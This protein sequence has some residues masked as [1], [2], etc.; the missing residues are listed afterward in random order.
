[1]SNPLPHAEELYSQDGSAREEASR[2]RKTALVRQFNDNFG[3]DENDLE[4]WHKLCR[5]IGIRP[6]PSDIYS[7]RQAVQATHVNMVD[8]VQASETGGTVPVFDSEQE[9]SEYTIATGKFFPR[10][11]VESSDLLRH[12]L[13][14]INDPNSPSSLGPRGSKRKRNEYED[15]G[16]DGSEGESGSGEGS[17]GD[18]YSDAEEDNAEDE[19]SSDDDE[20]ED[21][22]RDARQGGG[23]GVGYGDDDEE[24]DE[25]DED[26]DDGGGGVGAYGDNYTN[27]EYHYDGGYDEDEGDNGYDDYY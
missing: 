23:S 17:E 20:D 19:G 14:H 16:E 22:D 3:N 24:E 26:D 5:V 27:H 21:E 12:C 15:E 2:A 18:D 11:H 9:L 13:R 4:A 1:M 25:E 7:C 6:V 10:D 8:V